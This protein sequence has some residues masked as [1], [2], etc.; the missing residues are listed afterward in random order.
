M[1][2]VTIVPAGAGKAECA[3]SPEQMEQ[4]F[5]WFSRCRTILRFTAC[6][7]LKDSRRAE[8]AVQNCWIHAS[9]NPPSFE[10]EGDFRCWIV[11]QLI[12]EALSIHH[13]DRI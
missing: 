1:T 9:R 10:N 8:R 11:R 7:I 6:R 4:F 2:A 3:T 5:N 12:D 13:H